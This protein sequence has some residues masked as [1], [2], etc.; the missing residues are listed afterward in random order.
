MVK[1]SLPLEILL[2]FF[3]LLS[4]H[5]PLQDSPSSF[6]GLETKVRKAFVDIFQSL[7]P[8]SYVDG[9]EFM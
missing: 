5:L 9:M 7:D 8:C 2:F 3:F 4:Y 1:V 6:S